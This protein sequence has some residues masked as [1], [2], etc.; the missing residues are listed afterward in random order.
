MSSIILRISTGNI[1]EIT[2]KA[3]SNGKYVSAVNGGGGELIAN[4]VTVTDWGKFV[5]APL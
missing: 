2:M 5:I 4:K 1:E 3:K